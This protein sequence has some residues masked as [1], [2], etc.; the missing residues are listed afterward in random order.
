MKGLLLKDWY[1]MK[2]YL[3]QY[4][5]VVIIFTACGVYLEMPSYIVAMSLILGINI[6]YASFSIDENGG[7]GYMLSCPVGRR[8][9]IQ[10]KYLIVLLCAAFIFVYSGIS[11]II[12]RLVNRTYE[13][14]WPEE[15]LILL[16]LY[17][18]IMGILIPCIYY[19]GLEKARIIMKAL[20]IVP[21]LGV[22]LIIAFGDLHKA[23]WLLGFLSPAVAYLAFAAILLFM[24]GSY[25]VS[26][27]IFGSM[28]F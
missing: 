20:T 28:D 14:S 25:R 16:C 21:A 23:E 3:R 26:L 17:L 18:A 13:G 12:F 7:Y 15:T 8:E 11:Q 4:A 19:Y 1:T 6:G 22:L 27:K 5:F 24:A 10:E 9:M 2:Q